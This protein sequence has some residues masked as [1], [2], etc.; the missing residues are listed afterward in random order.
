MWFNKKSNKSTED[1][2]W[3]AMSVLLD[4]ELPE[5]KRKRRLVLWLWPVAAS[6]IGAVLYFTLSNGLDPQLKEV[7]VLKTTPMTVGSTSTAVPSLEQSSPEVLITEK[8]EYFSQKTIANKG[9]TNNNIATAGAALL[10][11]VVKEPLPKAATTEGTIQNDAVTQN[12]EYTIEQTTADPES[13]IV[14][15]DIKNIAVL[16]YNLNYQKETPQMRPLPLV[17]NKTSA[18]GLHPYALAGVFA[19][20]ALDRAGYALGGGIAI[21]YK[22]WL[23]LSLGIQYEKYRGK[24]DYQNEVA[25]SISDLNSLSAYTDVKQYSVPLLLHVAVPSTPLTVYGGV[26]KN[27]VQNTANYYAIPSR[28]QAE[29]SVPGFDVNSLSYASSAAASIPGTYYEWQLGLRLRMWK[30]WSIGLQYRE[31]FE[32]VKNGI[33]PGFN[34]L[35]LN[36]SYSLQ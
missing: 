12:S 6:V 9:Q 14:M 20:P 25:S 1:R 16:P 29:L 27:F 22:K 36:L 2:G 34:H 10:S 32:K 19:P 30:K 7:A 21:H 23:G 13:K 18:F 15:A 17:M 5:N 4:K 33:I 11:S 28:S 8:K 31:Q 35:G 26:A 3:R 24:Y